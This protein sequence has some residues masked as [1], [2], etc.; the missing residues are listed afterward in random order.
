MSN[1]KKHRVNGPATFQN[2]Q[3]TEIVKPATPANHTATGFEA[4]GA[5]G[6]LTEVGTWNGKALYQAAGGWYFG[7]MGTPP[8][9]WTVQ[10]DDPRVAGSNGVYYRMDENIAGQY[11]IGG[12]STPAGSVS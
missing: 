10:S 1:Q 6:L 5:N 12:M 2:L 3:L 8:G 4:P 7:W 11:I 9:W